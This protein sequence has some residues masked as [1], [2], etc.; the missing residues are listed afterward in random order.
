[1]INRRVVLKGLASLVG[2]APA[3][4][5]WTSET[6]DAV[7]A[8][9]VPSALTIASTRELGT[10][11]HPK[12][13]AARDGGAT[14]LIGGQLLWMF[15]DTLVYGDSHVRSSSA[16]LANPTN[17]LVVHEPLDANGAPFQFVPFTAEEQAYNDSTGKP[18]DRIAIWPASVINYQGG[19]LVYSYKL[20]VQPGFLNYQFIGVAL[21]T[22]RAGQ[23]AATREPGLLFTDPEPDFVN[24]MIYHNM[25]Y[26]FGRP[27]NM[28]TSNAP[29]VAAR[30][31]LAQATNRSAY[32]FWN[33]SSWTSDVNQVTALFTGIPGAMSV[34]YNS[35]LGQFLAVYSQALSNDV[36]MQTA[37]SIVGP[38]S[39]PIVAFSGLPPSQGANDYAGIEHPELAKNGG[40]TIYVSYF[41]P[42]SDV[43]GE[44]HLVEVNFQ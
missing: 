44:M 18:D 23:T 11:G 27:H 9:R 21:A 34:S 24:A 15:D 1:M 6:T 35:Y 8:T 43:T 33:G 39:S 30:A 13:V 14:A 37:P 31:P 26:V 20:K 42:L 7:A 3:L 19:G 38:W 28:D 32:T 12:S 36:M 40:R 29:Y 22:V 10:V 4:L 17:P 16:A 25:V 5:D 2:M 41:Q